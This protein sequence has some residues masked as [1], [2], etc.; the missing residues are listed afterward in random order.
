MKRRINE[1]K[2]ESLQT[3]ETFSHEKESQRVDTT[4]TPQS[5][6]FNELLTKRVVSLADACQGLVILM[7]VDNE[8]RDFN[9]QLSF[10]RREEIV[11]VTIPSDVNQNKPLRKGLAAILFC[12]MLNVKGGIW[13]HLFGLRERYA[14]RELVHERI[15]SS[16]YVH[17][18]VNGEELIVMLINAADYL[19]KNKYNEPTVG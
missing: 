1:E 15:M 13:I 12:R 19:S 5:R 11:P 2:R 7:E 14:L 4:D 3:T 6:Y 18:R 10:L 17:E 16:G 8:Y 9:S